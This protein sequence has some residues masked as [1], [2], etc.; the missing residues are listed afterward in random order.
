M[1]QD[2]RFLAP[3]IFFLTIIGSYSIQNN[4]FDVYTMLFFGFVGYVGRK[5]GFGPGPIVLGIILGKICEQGL[6]Q[7][8]LM[9]KA[10]GSVMGVF[11][12]RPISII[13]IILTITSAA[14]PL[15][16]KLL[17]GGGKHAKR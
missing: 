5:A 14:W 13:L 7:S 9:G 4:L 1:G 16:Q 10:A 8:I 6:V 15:I 2:I 3:V 11:F 12:T 17:G